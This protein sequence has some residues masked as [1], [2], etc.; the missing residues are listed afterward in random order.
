VPGKVPDAGGGRTR[1]DRRVLSV[2][3]ESLTVKTWGAVRSVGTA[4]RP[5]AAGSAAARRTAAACLTGPAA[6]IAAGSA[7][8]PTVTGSAV[9]GSVIAGAATARTTRA[10]TA[11][12]LAGMV[13]VQNADVG[14]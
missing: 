4:S 8:R 3:S 10:A 1:T 6:G 5:A 14:D 7:V 11:G 12:T 9:T 2:L 13:A